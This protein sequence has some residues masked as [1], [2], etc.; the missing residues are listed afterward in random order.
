MSV[1]LPPAASMAVVTFAEGLLHLRCQ[2]SRADRRTLRV[3]GNLAGERIPGDCLSQ[4]Q[5]CR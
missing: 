5:T 4:W 3:P 1:E 2:V